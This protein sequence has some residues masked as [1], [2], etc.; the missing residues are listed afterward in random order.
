M[1][2]KLIKATQTF[3]EFE[4]NFDHFFGECERGFINELIINMFCRL[5][6]HG[7]VV[8]PYRSHVKQFYFIREGIVE[9]FNH[10]NDEVIKDL[11]VMYMPKYSYFGDY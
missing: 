8:L 6:T 9:I 10:E 5:F 1:Q 2:T 11:A 4:K 3:D 7:K